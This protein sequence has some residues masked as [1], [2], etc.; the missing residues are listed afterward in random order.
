M[1]NSPESKLTQKLQS[2]GVYSFIADKTKEAILLLLQEA[3][4]IDEATDLLNYFVDITQGSVRISFVPQEL[5]DMIKVIEKADS[6]QQDKTNDPPKDIKIGIL[7]Y[8]ADIIKKDKDSATAGEIFT[9]LVSKS[10]FTKEE[11]YTFSKTV[12][13]TMSNSLAYRMFFKSLQDLVAI[14]MVCTPDSF[15]RT[16][17]YMITPYGLSKI[18]KD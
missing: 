18:T 15:K 14:G 11:Q 2:L 6:I 9:E 12:K 7:M 8:L 10:Y 17:L 16:K 3:E 4:T 13:E 1:S 5:Q